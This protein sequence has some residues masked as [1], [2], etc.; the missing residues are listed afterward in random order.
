MSAP[1]LLMAAWFETQQWAKSNTPPDTKFLVPPLPEGFRVFSERTSWVDWKDGD[2]LYAFPAY[3]TEW[4]RRL[5]AIGMRLVVGH[6]DFAGMIQQYKAQ[7]WE[8]LLTVAREHH[9]NYIIQ[10][11]EVFYPVP[12]V[13]TNE[14]FSV[15]QALN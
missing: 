2:A 4:R 12:A 14:T 1:D 10:Y 11:A 5:D 9:I 8:R 15:Y 3:A 6:V 7:S 13:F